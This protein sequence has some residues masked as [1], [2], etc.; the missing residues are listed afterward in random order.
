VLGS[1]TVVV[2]FLT[3][4]HPAGVSI[5]EHLKSEGSLKFHFALERHQAEHAGVAV[6]GAS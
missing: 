2:S 5:I 3:T 6:F 1:I 4:K